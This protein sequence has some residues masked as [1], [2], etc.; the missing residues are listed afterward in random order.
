MQ[1]I[2]RVANTEAAMI[3]AITPIA[4]D[5]LEFSTSTVTKGVFCRSTVDVSSVS[6]GMLCILP[7]ISAIEVL[8]PIG[9]TEVC[10]GSS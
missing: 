9:C 8:I 2:T 4:G 5:F 6:G 10:V 7:I 1:E 3:A